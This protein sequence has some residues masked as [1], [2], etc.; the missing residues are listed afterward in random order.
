VPEGEPNYSLP[1][2]K[3]LSGRLLAEKLQHT[4]NWKAFIDSLLGEVTAIYCVVAVEKRI[5][6]RDIS[7]DEERT[8]ALVQGMMKRLEKLSESMKIMYESLS[9]QV[10]IRDQESRA[11]PN[12]DPGARFNR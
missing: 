2:L 10:T 3:D 6:G 9:R 12:R 5:R 7:A 1:N 4:A 11:N 8:Y